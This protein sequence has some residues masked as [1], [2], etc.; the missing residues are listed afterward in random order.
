M[1]H[2]WC[3]AGILAAMIL[4]LSWNGSHLVA[5]SRPL[6]EEISLASQSARAGEWE[7]AAQHTAA[8]QEQ[9]E[10]HTGYLRFVQCHANL[11]T[12]SVLFEE[13]KAFLAYR[14]TGSYL[15]INEQLLGGIKELSELENLTPGNLF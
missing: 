6:C 1:K 9:W 14:E 2:L 8:A 10:K 3:S 12:I 7:T 11:E 4:L 13:S 5:L 15:A